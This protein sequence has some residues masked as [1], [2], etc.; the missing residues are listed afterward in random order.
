[1]HTTKKELNKSQ[2]QL[3]IEVSLDELQPYL[4]KTA[5]KIS[6][7][8]TIPGFRPGKAPYDLVKQTAG[9][10]TIWERAIDDVV[11]KTLF[12]ALNTKLAGAEITGQP[13]INLEK[14]APGNPLVYTAIITLVPAIKLGNWKKIK[15]K[16]NEVTVDAAAVATMLQNLR[17]MRAK[18][19][20]KLGALE[21]GDKAVVSF[22]VFVDGVPIEGGQADNYDLV[23]GEG[24]FIPGF[25]EQL[26]GLSIKD[27]KEFEL[28]FPADYHQPS[29]Q[30]K[31][32]KFKVEVKETF[33]RILPELNDDFAKTLG[34]YTDM[35][36]VKAGI[37]SNLK[38]E[39][40]ERESQRQELAML[41]ALITITQFEDLPDSLIQNEAHKMVH[42][43]EHSIENQ[44]LNFADYLT[45]LKKTED[46]L[47]TDMLPEATKR[48]QTALITRKVAKDQNI[49]LDP[50]DIDAEIEAIS[51]MY[52]GN[53]EALENLKSPAYKNYLQNSL[54]NRK[55]IEFLRQE[56]IK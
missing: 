55:V 9:E 45:H 22:N 50:Q 18:E 49:T 8:Q 24:R 5:A 30:G 51:Q 53:T 32:A 41:E 1:M 27:K 10:M 56:I 28:R 6:E 47:K 20:V 42:E 38:Q 7:G 35:A 44:G 48:V 33:R 12:T 21:P 4:T 16:K 34:G 52:Q 15:V 23:I 40:E 11:S 29:L 46:E 2:I 26:V 17:A 31:L 37:E 54:L 14:M 36:A 3:T 13:Q 43:L 39:A 19:T 25:E